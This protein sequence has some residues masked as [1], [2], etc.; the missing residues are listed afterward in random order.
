MHY[1]R[2][3]IRWKTLA[4]NAKSDMSDFCNQSGGA[5]SKFRSQVRSEI[6][7]RDRDSVQAAKETS[8][9]R[10]ALYTFGVLKDVTRSE[11]LSDFV[12]IAPSVYADAET[13]DG[14]IAHAGAAR[15]D[16]SGKSKL[17]E[18]FG[19]W[20]IAVAPRFYKGSTKPGED[21]IITTLSLWRDIEAARRFTYGGLH[22]T[23]LRR[24]SEWF[25]K[26][27]W[28][29]YVLW[30]VADENVPTWTEGARKLEAIDD[31]GPTST[32]FDFAT[33]FD[34]AGRKIEPAQ[35]N[36]RIRARLEQ[37]RS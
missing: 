21:T 26:P 17:G 22:R 37:T 25:Q 34:S 9:P 36:E 6:S 32:G 27:E 13:V 15:P 4:A 7:I 8:M 1:P 33:C 23:A 28:P 20:G 10:L 2:F 16:L 5:P 19:P 12:A 11:I 14:F 35:G 3:R 29:G 31:D 30:W 18:D 24:R